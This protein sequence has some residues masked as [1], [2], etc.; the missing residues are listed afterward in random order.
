[1]KNKPKHLSFL[2]IVLVLLICPLHTTSAQEKLNLAAGV[3][4]PELLNL[5]ARFQFQQAQ[6]GIGF[7]TL[8]VKDELI[9]SASTDLFFHFAGQSAFS[10]RR[11]WYFRSGLVFL[12]DENDALI[13]KYLYL[14]LRVGRDL[15]LTPRLGIA[16]DAGILFELYNET[17]RPLPGT[18]WNFDFDFPVLPTLGLTLYYRFL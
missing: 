1:M 15:N 16:P 13:D 8:P 7:G 6:F 17:V 10:A 18:G 2:F 3:G 14:N 4:L 5:N 11:P 12:R 9:W